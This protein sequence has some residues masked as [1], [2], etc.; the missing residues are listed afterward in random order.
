MSSPYKSPRA[1]PPIYEHPPMTPEK[2]KAF[3]QAWFQH[4]MHSP[5]PPVDR[6]YYGAG[7]ANFVF[8][9]MWSRPGLDRRSRRW[10]TLACVGAADTAIPIRTHIYAALKSGDVTYE[11]MSEFVLHFAVYLGWPKASILQSTMEEQWEKVL[12]EGGPEESPEP[13]LSDYTG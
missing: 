5:A 13:V 1:H 12:S 2:R 4:V 3:G 9:E 7:I 10:I 11:E 8:G 6:V